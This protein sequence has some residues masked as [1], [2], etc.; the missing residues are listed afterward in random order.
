M[1]Y[2]TASYIKEAENVPSPISL[3]TTGHFYGIALVATLISKTD[4]AYYKYEIVMVS[5]QRAL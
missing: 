4:P 2:L 5:R 1:N 3:S